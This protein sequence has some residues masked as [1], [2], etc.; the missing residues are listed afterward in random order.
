[1]AALASSCFGARAPAFSA[2]PTRRPQGRPAAHV[3]PSAW[4]QLRG[5]PLH[6]GSD[7]GGAWRSLFAASFLP[8]TENP[9]G[10]LDAR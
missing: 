5:G 1:M 8:P 4:G 3:V 7:D 2:R 6:G 9:P 10:V